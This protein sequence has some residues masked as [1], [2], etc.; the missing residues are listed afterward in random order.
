LESVHRTRDLTVDGGVQQLPAVG[1][2]FGF[3]VHSSLP[4]ELVRQGPGTPLQVTE[5]DGEPPQQVGDL[6]REWSA[7]PGETL[8]TQLYA[9]PDIDLFWLEQVGW[10][11][12]DSRLPRIDIPK[13]SPGFGTTSWRESILW[14]VPAAVCAV[15]RGLV[16][17]HAASVEV[18]GVGLLLAGPGT[19]GKTTLSGAFLR[20]GYRLL[21]D[22]MACCRLSPAPAVFPGPTLLRLRKDVFERLDFPGTSTV[23]EFGRKVGVVLDESQRGGSEPVP[24]GGIILLKKSSGEPTLTRAAHPDALRDLFALSFKGVLDVGKSFEDLAVLVNQV[25]VWYLERRLD[26]SDLPRTVDSIVRTIR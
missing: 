6:V 8:R 3:A 21:S 15:R 20:A 17:T 24:L 10:F 11:R 18:N 2:C 9:R 4:F 13:L 19:F 22:D 12:I 5:T 1:S 16:S 25:P 14:G 26:F 23:R 7:Q